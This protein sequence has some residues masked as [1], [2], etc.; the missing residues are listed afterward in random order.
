MPDNPEKNA[1]FACY[2]CILA[3]EEHG[4]RA[5]IFYKMQDQGLDTVVFYGMKKPT[6]NDWL[7]NADFPNAWTIAVY[8]P[9]GELCA[10]SWVNG[11]MGKSAWIHFVVFE[12]YREHMVYI[13]KKV[14][15]RFFDTKQFDSLCGLTPSVY[16]HALNYIQKL[17]FSISGLKAKSACYIERKNRYVD[18]VFSTLKKEDFH[19]E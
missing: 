7:N 5:A 9:D 2:P 4:R 15:A 8:T 6:I 14:V 17:G 12:E 18:G 10:A 16:R 13:G 3:P 11:F 1:D 19:A